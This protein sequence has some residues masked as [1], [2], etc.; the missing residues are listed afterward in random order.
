MKGADA[1][2][3]NLGAALFGKTRRSL[4]A[5]FYGH[6]D[7]SFYL[8]EVV[9]TIGAGQG[10]VQREL[11]Q[12]TAVGLLLRTRRG[13]QVYYQANPQTPV[14]TELKSLIVKTA[15]VADVVRE[16]LAELAE[17]IIVA[18]VHGSLARGRGQAGSDVDLVVIG[19]LS[20][21]EVVTALRPAQE[22]L[23]R[24][25]NATVYSATE[26]RKKLRAGHQFLTR[27]MTTPKIFLAGG[28]HELANLG[29]KRLA[30]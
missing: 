30:R 23:Q 14:F 3:N 16:A 25:V 20:F 18:F 27:I 19:D 15:G 8:R 10:A 7:R 12:L 6:P 28:D 4:L 9:R 13:N 26:F 1:S 11:A 24:E 17:N 5:L 2:L 29:P 22:R 21:G